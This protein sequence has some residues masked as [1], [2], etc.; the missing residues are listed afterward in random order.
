MVPRDGTSLSQRRLRLVG[1]IQSTGCD[2]LHTYLTSSTVLVRSR[3]PICWSAALKSF[4]LANGRDAG[5]NDDDPGMQW[6]STMKRKKIGTIVGYKRVVLCANCGHEL[7]VFRTAE[8]EIIDMIC[9]VAR[10][11]PYFN[12]RCVHAFIDQEFH[13]HPARA[14]S[15]RVARIGFCFAHGREAGRP[16]RGKA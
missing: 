1:S 9:H 10:R 12:Q 6:F 7:P 14:R 15:C 3:A 11:M 5:N 4:S 2:L 13:R 8:T 16:R